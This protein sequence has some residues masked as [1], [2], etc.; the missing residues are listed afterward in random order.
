MPASASGSD[1]IGDQRNISFEGC[2]NFR[3]LGGF[4]TNDGR[5]VRDGRLYRSMTPEWMSD[6]DLQRARQELGIGLVIDLRGQDSPT[7]G[8]IGNPPASRVA[9]GPAR[10]PEGQRQSERERWEAPPEVALPRVLDR[11]TIPEAVTALADNLGVVAL[12][13]CR[14]GKDRTGVFS[15]LLLKL[16]GVSD[17][18]II[19]DYLLTSVYES[20]VRVRLTE[21]GEPPLEEP[22]LVREPPSEAGIRATLER[23]ETE[24]GG[25]RSYLEQRG[26]APADL[27]ALI[28]DLLEPVSS[29]VPSVWQRG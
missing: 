2:F 23:L 7:S 6:A 16:L 20:Q 10:P 14:L 11:T 28:D 29:P 8:E 15:A 12:V 17:D 13:H 1:P 22:R 19:E 4:L 25:P 21:M 3:S 5:R 18:Q 26:L 24:F 9:V 27:D